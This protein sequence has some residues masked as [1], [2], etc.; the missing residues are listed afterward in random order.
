MPSTAFVITKPGTEA[1]EDLAKIVARKEA[2]R[3]AGSGIFW[4][5]IGSSLGPALRQAAEDAGG[6]L[7]LLFVTHERPGRPKA[8]DVTP[9]RVF[10]WTKWEDWSDKQHNVPSHVQVTS[11]GDGSKHAHYALVCR[12]EGPIGL[13]LNGPKF[14]M[15]LCETK[16]GKRPGSSQVTALLWGDISSP[17][18]RQG[19]YRVAFRA[20]LVAPWQAKLVEYRS[21]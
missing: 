7:P 5:G 12:A 6:E 9:E 10:R 20:T 4:W 13:D 11:R 14:D 17:Q 21:L 16:A 8:Q 2:E 18:H 3:L 19:Q 1:G 15:A